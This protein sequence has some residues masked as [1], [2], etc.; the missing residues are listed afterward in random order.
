MI[1][2]TLKISFCRLYTGHWRSLKGQPLNRK[3]VESTRSVYRRRPAL[4]WGL[5]EAT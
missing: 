1:T 3:P 5:K 4:Y 2:M